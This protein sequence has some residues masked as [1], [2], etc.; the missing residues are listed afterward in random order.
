[1]AKLLKD[2]YDEDY[3]NLLSNTI[4]KEYA[5][6]HIEAFKRS[7]FDE[8]WHTLELK[9]RMRHISSTLGLY[10]PKEY[11][12]AVSILKVAFSQMNFDYGLQNMIF[13][14]F[15]EVY[16][17]YDFEI[18]MDALA[19]FTINSSSEFAVR[20]FILKYELK[21]MQQM[22]SWASS[23]N[24]HVRRLASEGCRPR[25]P[26]AIALPTYKED[27]TLVLEILELLK[28]DES[29][30]VRKS[31]A[32]N[33]NDISKD[34][35]ITL[36]SLTKKWISHNKNRDALLKHA[37][38]TLLKSSNT[39]VLALF[40]YEKLHKLELINFQITKQVRMGKK[41]KFSFD[42]VAGKNLG[43]IRIEFALN[44]LRQ[45]NKY[46]KKV[47]KIAEGVYKEK[48]RQI[49]KT[50]SFKP[51]STRKYY[52]GLQTLS[53]IINGEVF[54]EAEFMLV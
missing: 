12:N 46:N 37:C 17:L 10:L 42:L 50:Y 1:M 34:N 30:Y 45:N 49:Q 40:G 19:H 14:D 38:R 31:V 23:K 11:L 54:K 33:L 2:L 16:G 8:Q 5:N 3:I 29:A 44:F 22:K 47:F 15:V 9:Q 27:P 53:I 39:E 20:A 13:Q 6:F 4:F 32:N 21:T 43:K 18:S 7:V 26:W 51:I 52:K 28:D 48:E 41:L 25:L 35:P 24:E 36:I